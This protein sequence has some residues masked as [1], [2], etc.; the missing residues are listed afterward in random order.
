MSSHIDRAAAV[1]APAPH[2]VVN[3]QLFPAQGLVQI[4]TR[5]PLAIGTHATVLSF[6]IVEGIFLTVLQMRLAARGLV[7][8]MQAQ[9]PG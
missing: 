3:V 6:D 7:V 9:S 1:S 5:A 4:D 2:A 8:G